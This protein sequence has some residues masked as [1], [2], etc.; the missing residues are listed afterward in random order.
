[1]VG[2]VVSKPTARNTTSLVRAPAG[3]VQRVA[4]RVDD[5]ARR[6][7]AARA[8]SRLVRA[9]RHPHQV[10]EGGRRWSR[11]ARR[12]RRRGP[13]S[14]TGVTHTGQPGP[15]ISRT[16]GGSIRRRPAAAIAWVWVPHTSMKVARRPRR[17]AAV[18]IAAHQPGT[19]AGSRAAP[20]QAHSAFH[21]VGVLPQQARVSAASSASTLPMAKPA[22]MSRWSPT[23]TSGMQHQRHL[24]A[25]AVQLDRRPRSQSAPPAPSE[26]PGTSDLPGPPNSTRVER[27]PTRPDAGPPH[28]RRIG[29]PVSSVDRAAC[30]ERE[31]EREDPH[32]PTGSTP[33]A[34]ATAATT[35]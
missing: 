22:W 5:L 23:S 15:E 10:A 9:R 21:R 29:I 2:T 1:M 31:R 7:P 11:A 30:R 33:R 6:R 16:D 34:S 3:D 28:R 8:R 26:S 27:P 19:A 25:D 4:R 32:S 14:P 24:A 20:G 13:G 35:A 17:S 18:A 12:G